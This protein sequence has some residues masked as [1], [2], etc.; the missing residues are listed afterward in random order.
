MATARR[1]KSKMAIATGVLALD[2]LAQDVYKRSYAATPDEDWRAASLR[3]SRH[4]A[5]AESS[6]LRERWDNRF[7][8]Q[9]TTGRFM[10]GGRFWYGAGR[11]KAQLLNCFVIPTGDSREGWGDTLREMLIISGLG[12]GVGIN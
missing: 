11:P 10:P 12:G 6:E 3:V 9:I 5:P 7:Y 1:G 8:G 2:D 4:V